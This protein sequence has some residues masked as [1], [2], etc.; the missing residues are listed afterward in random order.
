MD[1]GEIVSR[2][3]ILAIL[4][5]VPLERTLDYAGAVVKGGVRFFEVALNSKDGLEQI[6]LLRRRYGNGVWWGRGRRLQW[7]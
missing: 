7:D 2:N 6:S 3:P 1:M 4:R 5:N